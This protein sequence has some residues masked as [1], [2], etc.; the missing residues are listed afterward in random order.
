MYEER[1]N[2]NNYNA[3]KLIDLSSDLTDGTFSDLKN[4]SISAIPVKQA[5]GGLPSW[6]L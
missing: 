2:Y 4:T 1:L 5:P 6:G 3:L